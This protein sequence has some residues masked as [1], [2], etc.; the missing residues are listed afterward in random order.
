MPTLY[1]ILI[2][3]I[4]KYYI[5]MTEEEIDSIYRGSVSVRDKEK[6]LTDM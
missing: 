5:I 1:E 6:K 2:L 4:D 3:D